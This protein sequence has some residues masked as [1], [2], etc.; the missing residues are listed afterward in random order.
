MAGSTE[1]IIYVVDS[2]SWISVEGNPASNRI[3][4]NLD[5]LIQRGII[6]CPPEVWAEIRSEYMVAWLRGR[7]GSVVHNIRVNLDYLKLVGEVTGQFPGMAGARGSRNRAD[8]YV[9]AYAA[10]RNGTEN[11]T[12]CVVVCDESA[13]VRPNRKIPTAYQA[14]GVEP[15][16]L[17]EMLRREFP[18]E[19]W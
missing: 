17:L 5:I 10:H 8:P 15:I 3:L 4:S 16:N 1:E 18:H 2:S 14:F 12:R 6:K 19:G 9:V 7:K 13:T 11:P